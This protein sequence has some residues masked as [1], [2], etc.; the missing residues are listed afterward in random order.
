MQRH[1]SWTVYKRVVRVTRTTSQCATQ[2]RV[3]TKVNH[4]LITQVAANKCHFPVTLR[5]RQGDT[6]EL[7]IADARRALQNAGFDEVDYLEICDAVT[8]KPVQNNL[9]T[10]IRILGAAR[11]GA[12]RLIDNIALDETD[13]LA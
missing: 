9:Q 3:A 1:V 11:L 13:A 7:V 6:Q 8:L 12:T 5:V 4:C 10:P 2:W